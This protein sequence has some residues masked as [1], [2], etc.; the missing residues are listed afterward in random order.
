MKITQGVIAAGLV[1]AAVLGARAA[2]ADNVVPAGP[3][4]GVLCSGT[5]LTI[6]IGTSTITCNAMSWTGSAFSSPSGS[7]VCT[8]G[9]G[10]IL[11]NC[12]VNSA[13]ATIS[14]SCTTSGI[15]GFCFSSQGSAQVLMPR[16][17]LRCTTSLFGQTCGVTFTPATGATIFGSWSNA[18]SSVTITNQ[19]I[20]ALTTGGFPC[21]SSASLIIS[22]CLAI[23]PVI[24][25]TSN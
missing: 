23:S 11:T 7:P 8:S 3:I 16:G 12:T 25:I 19:S 22:H 24:T 20:S 18:T 21:P 9:P 6:R 15:W 4:T 5:K 17:G 14:A 2:S 13:G 10:P 1:A